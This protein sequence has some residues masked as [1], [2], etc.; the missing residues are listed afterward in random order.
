MRNLGRLAGIARPVR[1]V[2][3]SPNAMVF[4]AGAFLAL[5]FHIDALD[6]IGYVSPPVDK[7]IWHLFFWDDKRQSSHAASHVG[8]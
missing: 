1:A 5:L 6:A 2:F 3:G 7:G 8:Q 4:G